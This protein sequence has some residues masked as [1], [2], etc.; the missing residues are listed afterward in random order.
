MNNR[1]FKSNIFNIQR[2]YL[3][4]PRQEA[5]AREVKPAPQS[6][7][8]EPHPSANLEVEEAVPSG[9]RQSCL[10]EVS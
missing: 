7:P 2:M 3:L 6:A 9:E 5:Q 8:C 1:K 4:T 10:W